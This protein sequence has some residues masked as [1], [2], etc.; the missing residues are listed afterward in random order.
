MEHG[1]RKEKT[2]E[3]LLIREGMPSASKERS[4]MST[5]SIADDT[6]YLM[7]GVNGVR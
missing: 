3:S 6:M 2:S 1:L 5:V 4:A 7:K